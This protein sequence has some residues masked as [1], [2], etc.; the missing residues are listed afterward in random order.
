MTDY[1]S[2]GKT[3][4]N[5]VVDLNNCYTHQS[6]YT[7]L[8]RS[9]SAAG[10]IILQG[11]DGRKITGGASG[12]LRQEF[13]DLEVLDEISR[14][15]YDGRLPQAV[16]GDRR[17][18]LIAAYRALKGESY[19]P[20]LVHNAI[21]WSRADPYVTDVDGTIELVTSIPNIPDKTLALAELG[22]LKP[23]DENKS[24]IPNTLVEP[25]RPSKRNVSTS[26]SHAGGAPRGTQWRDNS[27]AYDAIVTIL[28][29][30]WND[31][32]DLWTGWLNSINRECLGVL[33]NGLRNHQRGLYSL[34]G[35]R[36]YF[37]RTLHRLAPETFPW[38]GYTSVHQ[39]LDRTLKTS[40]PVL[41]SSLECP[42]C[43]TVGRR[44]AD[45]N[46]C[47]INAVAMN[48]IHSMEARGYSFST[49]T[50]SVCPNCDCDMVRGFQY[51]SSPQLLA[52][53][54]PVTRRVPEPQSTIGP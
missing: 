47:L 18:P 22:K 27:C 5:N 41:R 31:E 19:I 34:E 51:V 3:R 36:D 17:N 35:V 6:Y 15:T 46:S 14:L 24:T 52:F 23:T 21:R 38:G 16:Q 32:C 13:R 43:Q 33:A 2:Q 7:A 45:V 54:T 30:I 10:T 28:Y 40:A 1:A 44:S 20:S 9:A 8:S 12:A 50:A 26:A 49:P 48:T 42:Q 25:P 39:I 53:D 29:N 37:R 11:F 4:I